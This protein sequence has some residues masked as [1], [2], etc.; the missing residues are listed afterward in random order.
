MVDRLIQ[1]SD[2]SLQGKFLATIPRR[3]PIFDGH[4]PDYP[5]L[6]GVLSIEMIAQ[7]AGF[8]ILAYEKVEQMPFLIGVDQ[9]RFKGFVEPDE[10]LVVSAS[11]QHRGSG[12]WVAAGHA[13]RD[14]KRLTQAKLRLAIRDFPTLKMKH[15][16]RTRM[17][18]LGMPSV[19]ECIREEV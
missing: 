9:A 7:A 2:D 19:A 13:S 3:S 4:F 8:L 12:Y 18:E 1:V 15:H 14:S 16:I 11:L 17:S 10:T 5:I 6:P